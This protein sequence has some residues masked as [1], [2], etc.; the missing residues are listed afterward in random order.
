[1]ENISKIQKDKK[2]LIVQW[3][4]GEESLFNY[5]WLRDNCPTAHDKDSNVIEC[6]IFLNVSTN[7]NPENYSIN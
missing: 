6:L 1:M 7:I 4:D 5:L 2:N 3:S